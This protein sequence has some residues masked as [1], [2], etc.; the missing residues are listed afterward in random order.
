MES[1]F[2]G[3][4]TNEI[5]K[6]EEELLWWPGY[7]ANITDYSNV[8]FHP[9]KRYFKNF[10]NEVMEE[11]M[12]CNT[13]LKTIYNLRGSCKHSFLGNSFYKANTF[14]KYLGFFGEKVTIW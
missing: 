2:E 8:L 3:I 9:E 7:P 11:C 1:I 6:L 13:S 5:T 4:V 12:I 10:K 14:N